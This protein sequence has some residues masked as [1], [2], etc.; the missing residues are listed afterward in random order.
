MHNWNEILPALP[1]AAALR[2]NAATDESF[3]GLSS[4]R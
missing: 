3:L 1:D 4:S 2:Y